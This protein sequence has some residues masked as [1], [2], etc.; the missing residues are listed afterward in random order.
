MFQQISLIRLFFTSTARG[1]GALVTAPAVFYLR[2]CA[3]RV[4]IQYSGGN[5][6]KQALIHPG[7][8]G[9][10]LNSELRW[11]DSFHI[12]LANFIRIRWKT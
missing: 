3:L 1:G 6:R 9:G 8:C 11:V 10:G 5:V 7:V 12:V 4:H 2:L